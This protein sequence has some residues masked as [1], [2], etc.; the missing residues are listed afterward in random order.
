MGNHFSIFLDF[1][2]SISAS[3]NQPCG[4]VPA[5]RYQSGE[6]IRRG[7]DALRVR[8]KM[9]DEQKH[10]QRPLMW[11]E[12]GRMEE[13]NFMVDWKKMLRNHTFLLVAIGSPS[14]PKYPKS[15]FFQLFWKRPMSK[16]G[17]SSSGAPRGGVLCQGW[18]AGL[19][20]YWHINWLPICMHDYIWL[21]MHRHT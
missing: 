15:M 13:P 8:P 6:E 10:E 18:V 17:F 2:M 3:P 21:Y 4:E 20:G 5:G 16:T 19:V 11:E 7:T 1:S 12:H 14:G 9:G